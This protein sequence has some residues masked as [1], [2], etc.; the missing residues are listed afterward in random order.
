MDR[1]RRE[2]DYGQK[3]RKGQQNTIPMDRAL[4]D[5]MK[6]V[7]FSRIVCAGSLERSAE[8]NKRIISMDEKKKG[9]SR[10]TKNPMD[11]QLHF[12]STVQSSAVDHAT[13]SD[14]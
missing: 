1:S 10:Q 2:V 4:V 3:G 12:N 13:S 6:I 9:N 5:S 8:V 11:S 7:F 14:Y